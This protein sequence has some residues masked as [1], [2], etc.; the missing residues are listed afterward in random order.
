M[1]H[2][3]LKSVKVHSSQRVGYLT[4]NTSFHICPQRAKRISAMYLCIKLFLTPCIAVY[5][6]AFV[7]VVVNVLSVR[8]TANPPGRC[9]L[10]KHRMWWRSAGEPGGEVGRHGPAPVHAHRHTATEAGS[11]K[12]YH[13]PPPSTRLP[14]SP[15]DARTHT[16]ADTQEEGAASAALI[17]TV[18]AYLCL[19]LTVL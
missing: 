3:Y 8:G 12:S 19:L 9:C 7:C 18:A 17:K 1:T 6:C 4:T 2:L 15:G 5:F 11:S 14:P 16:G 13:R 10:Y